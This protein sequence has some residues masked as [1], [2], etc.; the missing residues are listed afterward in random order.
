MEIAV[1]IRLG[2]LETPRLALQLTLAEP[3]LHF[4]SVFHE[5]RQ[6]DCVELRNHLERLAKAQRNAPI[7]LLLDHFSDLF[8]HTKLGDFFSKFYLI[9]NFFMNRLVKSLIG[10]SL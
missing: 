6:G 4:S 7:H 5:S 1:S 9:T 3:A 2:L 8:L 10:Y